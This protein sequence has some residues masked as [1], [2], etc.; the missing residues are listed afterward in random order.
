MLRQKIDSAN[1]CTD[2]SHESNNFCF[3]IRPGFYNQRAFVPEDVG[4]DQRA[5]REVLR[6]DLV[7]LADVFCGVVKL[8]SSHDAP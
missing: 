1:K 2:S 8:R 5:G 3:P 7:A 4:G 6:E